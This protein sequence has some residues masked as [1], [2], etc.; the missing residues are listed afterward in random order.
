MQG[1]TDEA[2]VPTTN[3][4][5]DSRVLGI[6]VRRQNGIRSMPVPAVAAEIPT[7]SPPPPP[8]EDEDLPASKKP[9]LQVYISISTAVVG[10]VTTD[11]PYNTATNPVTPAA[12]LPSATTSCASHRNWKADEDAK[13]TEA[14]KK[15]G[16][17]WGANANLV[18]GRTNQECHLRWVHSMNATNVGNKGKTPRSWEPEEDANRVAAVT[19]H[20]N[21]WVAVANLVPGRTNQQCHLRWVHTVDPANGNKGKTPVNYWKLEDANLTKAVEK[22]GKDWVAVARLLASR[23]N[24]QCRQRWLYSLDP[25]RASNTVEEDPDRRQ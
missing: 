23:K 20:G 15:H 4:V 1:P 14:V 13:Q 11:P 8:P 12:S 17:Y 6:T 10:G 25:D 7:L 16:K 19:K 18:P 5:L 3:Y 21:N 22:H 24:I 9:R 2:S